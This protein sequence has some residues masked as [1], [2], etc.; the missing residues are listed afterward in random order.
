MFNTKHVKYRFCW[1]SMINR[2]KR[3]VVVTRQ[4]VSRDPHDKHKDEGQHEAQKAPHLFFA[5]AGPPEEGA[6]HKEGH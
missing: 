4:R 3:W 2:V 5:N 1:N 6:H